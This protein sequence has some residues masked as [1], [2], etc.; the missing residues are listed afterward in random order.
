MPK[1]AHGESCADAI[2]DSLRPGELITFTTLFQRVKPKGAWRD[3]TIRRYLMACVVNLPR[4]RLEW[5]SSHPFL[6]LHADGR[7]ELYDP[8]KHPDAQT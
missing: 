2:R 7:Y 8:A 5:P 1:G 6:F 3:A 4:A